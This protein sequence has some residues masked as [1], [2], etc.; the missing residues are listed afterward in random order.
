MT[1]GKLRIH[2]QR[3]HLSN[4]K[5]FILPRLLFSLFPKPTITILLYN[6][7]D[8]LLKRRPL[9]NRANLG[10]QLEIYHQFHYSLKLKT[11]TKE[12]VHKTVIE[13]VYG[14]LLKGWW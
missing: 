7:V 14:R 5:C 3:K 8:E 2:Y 1:L 6:D 11:D 10:R 12:N 9:E 13:D 4:G